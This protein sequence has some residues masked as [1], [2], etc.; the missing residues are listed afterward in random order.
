MLKGTSLCHINWRSKRMASINI[1]TWFLSTFHS[2]IH[3]I[4]F[5]RINVCNHITSKHPHYDSKQK[6]NA[7]L[8]WHP[9][10]TP[11]K[12]FSLIINFPVLPKQAIFITGNNRYTLLPF[13]T[14][15]IHEKWV[16]TIML[17]VTFMRRC[18]SQDVASLWSSKQISIVFLHI[19]TCIYSGPMILL[20][21]SHFSESTGWLKITE[22]RKLPQRNLNLLAP[23]SPMTQHFI[24]WALCSKNNRQL[25]LSQS[26]LTLNFE[27][28]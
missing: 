9:S 20:F 12:D 27:Q 15:Y 13:Y 19:S 2:Q 4:F 28:V 21:Y 17:C 23:E 24:N 22:W 6:K 16:R 11:Y 1:M 10:E 7:I 5:Q 14:T 8:L 18:Y 26:H 25:D 3:N